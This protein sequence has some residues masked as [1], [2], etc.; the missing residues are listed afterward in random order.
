[1]NTASGLEKACKPSAILV[2]EAT[3]NLV[4]ESAGYVESLELSAK[5]KSEP[6]K[7][8]YLNRIKFE[9]P[10]GP[11]TIGLDDDLF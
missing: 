7:A 3:A 8:L 4:G 5:G 2:C 6:L 9:G 11:I 1:M 10:K